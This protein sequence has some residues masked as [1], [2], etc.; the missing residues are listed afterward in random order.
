MHTRTITLSCVGI[1][2]LIRIINNIV[3]ESVNNIMLIL[4]LTD[5]VVAQLPHTNHWFEY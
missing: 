3:V 4:V 2:I 1:T 5:E